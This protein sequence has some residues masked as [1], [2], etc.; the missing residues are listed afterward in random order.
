MKHLIIFHFVFLM[1]YSNISHSNPNQYESFV[2]PNKFLVASNNCFDQSGKYFEQS[3]KCLDGSVKCL[4]GSVMCLDG[5]VKNLD[6][7]VKSLDGS[8]KYFNQSVTRFVTPNKWFVASN[9]SHELHDQSKDST[10]NPPIDSSILNHSPRKATLLSTALPG[11]G[12]VYNKKAWK[13]PII[14]TGFAVL[15]YFIKTN[16]DQYLYYRDAF[17]IR[18]RGDSSNAIFIKYQDADPAQLQAARDYY[19][20][21]RD[22]CYIFTGFLYLLNIADADVDAHL[23][24]FDVSDKLSVNWKPSFY[25]GNNLR[26]YAGITFKLNF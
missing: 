7:S 18:E 23:F 20:R 14:Y 13:I 3:G 26:N 25:Q 24:Y 17:R 16:N 2:T 11:L 21:N 9:N 5:S 19:R 10:N 8:V 12:Q 1:F 6:R 4:D 15:G 22:L